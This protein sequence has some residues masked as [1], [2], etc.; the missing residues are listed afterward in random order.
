MVDK[1]FFPFSGPVSFG[2]L[3]SKV[4]IELAPDDARAAIAITGA[5][6]V[7]AAEDGEIA[8]IANKKYAESATGSHAGVLI[9]AP[10]LE[11]ELPADSVILAVDSPHLVFAAMLDVLFPEVGR[12]IALAAAEGGHVP[13]VEDDVTIAP[14]A[15]FGPGVEIGKGTVIGPGAVIGR[16]VTIGRDCVIGANVSIE[17]AYLGDRVVLWAGVRI[18]T[19]GFGWL[20]HGVSNTKIPQLG[21]VI[22]Q[23]RVEIGANSCVDRGALGD[24][25]L[26]ENTKI[27]NLVQIGHNCKIGRNCLMAALAGI[28]GSTT[29]GDSVLMGGG[30][31]TSGH[32][33]IGSG[34][35]L[36]GRT[37]VSKSWPP[38]S[39]LA[40]FP[41]MDVKDYWR[42]LAILR[43]LRKGEKT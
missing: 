19:E 16:G 5:N 18:G 43:R 34:S 36:T 11:A 39:R 41:A 15:V 26:G 28:S 30:T 21:R 3:C 1:R 17:C 8:L 29:I 4:G 25:V 10:G 13:E 12:S 42:E 27:D 23:D 22:I 31:A 37:A 20:D 9:V 14:S 35:V 32:I 40:G 6:E 2:A 33:T 24:T 7:F 38:G